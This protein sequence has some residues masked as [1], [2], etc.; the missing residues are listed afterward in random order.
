MSNTLCRWGILGSA[1][2]AKKNWQGLRLAGN[3]VITGVASRDLARAQAFIDE[4]QSHVPF[5]TPPM[6]YGSYEALLAD[7]AIDAVYIPLP[8]AMRTEW[9]LRAVAA[10]KHVLVEKP[11]GVTTSEVDQIVAACKAANV[12]FMDGV[13]FMH[14][15]RL[16][17]MREALDDGKSVGEIRR[18]DTHFTFKGNDDFHRSNIRV[19]NSL[20][21]LGCL[22]DLGWYTIRF[23]L[24]A[25]KYQL[26]VSVTGR[27]IVAAAGDVPVEFAAELVF[28]GNVTASMF[29]SFLTENSQ[30]A[31]VSGTEGFL[32][33][34]DFVLP[35]FGS[36]AEFDVTKA[37]FRPSG[38][39]FNMEDGRTTV[40]STEY[41]NSHTS[42]QETNM[43]RTFSQLVLSGARDWSWG[44]ITRK[45]Q[46]VLDACLQSARN[47]STPVKL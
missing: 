45:T 4:C 42:A 28:P 17:K 19:Q 30:W 36:R 25:M 44:V 8:T 6:A 16:A 39:D 13:M 2:I 10:K 34:R 7:P 11:V 22:G 37:V 18:I 14:S 12:Q 24:W 15:A 43:A 5:P 31:N 20:E 41:S 21:P 3:A 35:F 29:C 40:V 23:A 9:V 33:L 26:P 47:G 32:H 27:T 46:Q 38:C 1:N